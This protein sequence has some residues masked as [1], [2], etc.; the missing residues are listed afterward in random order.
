MNSNSLAHTGEIC[1]EAAIGD[2]DRPN[3]NAPSSTEGAAHVE[4]GRV[5]QTTRVFY[6][7]VWIAVEIEPLDPNKS[8]TADVPWYRQGQ[9]RS[10]GGRAG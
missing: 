10:I 5:M 3:G 8:L 1:F 4:R 2:F 7:G 9:R 6:L